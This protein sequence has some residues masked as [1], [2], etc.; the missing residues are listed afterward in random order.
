VQLIEQFRP[1]SLEKTS[2]FVV[3]VLSDFVTTLIALH[4]AQSIE[5]GG[6][7]ATCEE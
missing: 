7:P 2:E 3:P 5:A 4:T 1:A 6:V